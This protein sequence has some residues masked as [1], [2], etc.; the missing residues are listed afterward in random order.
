MPGGYERLNARHSQPNERITFIKAIPG[1]THDLALDYLQAVAAISLPIMRAHSLIVPVLEEYPPNREFIGRNFNGGEV[2]QLV[3]RATG[4]GHWMPLRSVMMV[5]MHELAHCKEMNHSRRFW[6]VRNDYA[7]EL[8]ALWR[9]DYTGEGVWGRGNRL[10]SGERFNRLTWAGE[11]EMPEEMCGGMYRRRRERPERPKKP[12]RNYREEKERRNRRKFGINGQRL[13][14]AERTTIEI[15]GVDHFT[16]EISSGG[17]RP[18]PEKPAPKPRVAGSKRGRDLRAAAAQARFDALA[19]EAEAEAEARAQHDSESEFDSDF[20]S[21]TDTDPYPSD[22]DERHSATARDLD[23]SQMRDAQGRDLIRVD[24]GDID[25]DA[26]ADDGE[27]ADAVAARLRDYRNELRELEGLFGKE[28]HP[29]TLSDSDDDED[30]DKDKPLRGIKRPPSS[31]EANRRRT[32]VKKEEEPS[33][34][35]DAL[36]TENGCPVCTVYNE[37]K[38]LVCVACGNVLRPEFVPGAWKCRRGECR[39]GVYVNAGDQGRCGA[40]G[41]TR[42]R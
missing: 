21:S 4:T 8:K 25:G 29:I 22:Y 6:G 28:V 27:D 5:M 13:G 3:L 42:T 17:R 24:P 2:I 11:D 20:S 39:E 23:G 40:C 26:D 36:P 10:A 33:A 1:S 15:T 9:R 32:A 19:R 7:A 37:P 35:L 18:K 16:L 14:E 12:K 38:E 31:P 41:A 34:F 30:K